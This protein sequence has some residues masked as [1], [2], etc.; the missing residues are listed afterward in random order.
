MNESPNINKITARPNRELKAGVILGYILIAINVIS[1]FLLIPFIL[2]SVGDSGYGI[3]S[4][5]TAIISMFLIDLGLSTATTKFISNYRRQ[6]RQLDINRLVG[7]IFKI[8]M[9]LSAIILAA[10]TVFFI[11]IPSIFLEFTPQELDQLKI[12]FIMVG[13][14]S[15]LSF[16]FTILDG[17]LI[18]Y[19]RLFL[20]KIADIISKTAFI[21]ATI[22]VL[23]LDLGLYAL[24]ACYILH[25]IVGL[26]LKFIFVMT[27]TPISFKDLL[28]NSIDKKMMW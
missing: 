15:I 26:I 3:Y 24:T 27:K 20:N 16:P 9:I 6:N 4:S 18:A 14:Y 8:Y 10:T 5:A 11:F 12:V 23:W 25:G 7:T 28:L 21:I 1:G 22:I 17:V 2:D 19:E 13:A